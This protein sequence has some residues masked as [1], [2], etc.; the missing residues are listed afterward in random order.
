M[1]I[2]QHFR[3]HKMTKYFEEKDSLVFGYLLIFLVILFIRLCIGVGEYS[4]MNTPPMYGD[5]EAQRHWMEI[6]TNLPIEHWYEQTDDNDLQYWGLDYPPLTAYHSWLCGSIA[7]L[8]HLPQLIELNTSRGIETE[9]TKFFMR[10]TVVVSD[11]VFFISAVFA[12]FNIAYPTQRWNAKITAIFCMLLNPLYIIIDHGH[13][14]YNCVALGLVLWSINAMFTKHYYIGSVLFVC[15]ICFKII[16]LYYALPFF[17]YC[18]GI[19]FQSTSSRHAIAKI[20]VFGVVVIL[21]F[22]LI[23]SPWIQL[24]RGPLLQVIHRIFPFER[25]LFEDKVANFW[26]ST[27]VAIKWRTLFG[28]EYTKLLALGATLCGCSPCIVLLFK[29][30]PK[31]FVYALCIS[32][33]SFFLCSYQVHEKTIMFPMMPISLFIL[34]APYFISSLVWIAMFSMLPLLEKDGLLYWYWVLNIMWY[35]VTSW[36]QPLNTM[37]YT[38]TYRMDDN[39]PPPPLHP[40]IARYR[41]YQHVSPP[42]EEMEEELEAKD[43]R[44]RGQG[45]GSRKVAQRKVYPTNTLNGSPAPFDYAPLFWCYQPFVTVMFYF[46]T[47]GVQWTEK[48][49]DIGTYLIMMYCCAHFIFAWVL[50]VFQLLLEYFGVFGRHHVLLCNAIEGI[51][52]IGTKQK[53]A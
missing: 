6:T 28:S 15:S 43:R 27:N 20:A 31:F 42:K 41:L 21:T 53:K 4:G 2:E 49:P 50:F 36:I 39:S 8:T 11:A 45:N 33:L 51:N 34:E 46:M 24:G 18:L 37:Q 25:G 19:A 9:D 30:T 22:F 26:C 23:F 17:F 32:S 35:A 52:G 14:Q 5:Y 7:N 3:T 38:K 48:Y 1:K 40:I 16:S 44:Q 10:M 29:P 12:F 47:D 13:F